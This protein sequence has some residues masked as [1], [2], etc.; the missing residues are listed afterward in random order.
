[1]RNIMD[2]YIDPQRDLCALFDADP[3]YNETEANAR[4]TRAKEA[5]APKKRATRKKA[6]KS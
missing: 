2:G 5:V 4:I 1:M 6:V 3:R